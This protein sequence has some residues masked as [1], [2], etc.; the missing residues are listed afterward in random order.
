M[1]GA[2]RVTQPAFAVGWYG[3]VP[4]TGDFVSRRVPAPFRDPW[5]RWLQQAMADSREHLGEHWRDVYLTMPPW[6]FVLAPGLVNANAWAGVLLPSA[7]AVGRYFPLTVAAPLPP[8]GLDLAATLF[9]AAPW[10]DEIEALALSALSPDADREAIDGALARRPFQNAWVEPPS[11]ASCDATLPL[12]SA[13]PQMLAAAL[14]PRIERERVPAALG[15]VAARIAE[16][17]AAWLAEESEVFGR[18]LL[19]CEKLPVGE[20]FCAMMDGRWV[21]RGWG[22]CD[23]RGG[24]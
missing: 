7:D 4:S 13:S 6:R 8:S 20:L 23:L 21:E 22:R 18:S 2:E 10:F 5:D 14:P 16:P 24:A 17:G 12:R 1:I 11:A 15:D 19:L 9:G 3:K